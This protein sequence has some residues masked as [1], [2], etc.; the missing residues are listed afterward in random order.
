MRRLFIL[1]LTLLLSLAMV[2]VQ[3]NTPA[4]PTAS[5]V[6]SP[7]AQDD[8]SGLETYFLDLADLVRED[9]ALVTMRGVG[10]DALALSEAEANAVVADL[11]LL[12]PTVEA[13]AVPAAAEGYH[14]AYLAMLI[15][16]RDLAEHR[17]AASHQRLINNDRHL[18]G[19]LG[20]GV[21]Q[22]QTACGVERWNAAYES[23]FPD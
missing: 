2:P 12:I 20:L 13:L 22:G 16:Y 8:C 5:P 7:I 11:D 19:D 15:W 9:P 21:M 4:T 18:F 10:F 1:L 23:A 14:V 6:A 3:A 17:D